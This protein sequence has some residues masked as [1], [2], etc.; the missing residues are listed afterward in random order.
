MDSTT[1]EAFADELEKIGIAVPGALKLMKYPLMVGGGVMG[2]EHLKKMKK[3]YDIGR[4]VQEQ[5]AARGQ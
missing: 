2:W 5:M 1:V 3:R 4:A